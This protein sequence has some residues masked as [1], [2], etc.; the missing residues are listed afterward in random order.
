MNPQDQDLIAQASAQ[1]LGVSPPAAMAPQA[2]PASI[3]P[4]EMQPTPQEMAAKGVSPSTEGDLQSAD[5]AQIM[6]VKFGDDDMR[7]L[8]EAQV[9]GTFDRYSALNFKHQ[10]M[11]PVMDLA[12]KMLAAAQQKNPNASAKDL[13]KFMTAAAKSQTHNP[14]MGKGTQ[15]PAVAIAQQSQSAGDVDAMMKQW[16]DDNA[17]SLPPRF[18]ETMDGMEDMR[19]QNSELRGLLEK[20]IQGQQGVTDSTQKQ[21]DST[22]MREGNVIQQRIGNNLAKAQSALNLPDESEQEFM[23]FAYSRGYTVEDFIDPELTMTV[24]QDFKANQDAPELERL[25]G[26][27]QKRQAFTGNASGTPAV[28]NQPMASSPDKTFIDAAVNKAMTSRGQM[29]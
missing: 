8:S 13:A 19:S 11:K 12:E 21:L 4:Q 28:S 23:Q 26:I 15:E 27:T 2:P 5:A 10:N 18:R 29:G 25:R 24:A 9:K 7:E 17:V 20:V 14:Q 3:A 16:E 1:Q 6:R 22:D